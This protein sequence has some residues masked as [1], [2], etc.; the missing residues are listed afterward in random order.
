LSASLGKRVLVPGA[1]SQVGWFLVPRMA[2]AGLKPVPLQRGTR[3]GAGAKFDAAICLA[4]LDTLPPML[5]DLRRCGVRRLIAFSTTGRFYKPDSGDEAERRRVA[6]LVAAENLVVDL[7]KRHE[8]AWT[9]F[10]P[11]LVYGC[12]RDRNVTAIARF[13]RSFGF[14][15]IVDGGHG[16]RQ[17]VHAD[18]LASA[19]VAALDRAVTYCK[20]YTLSGGSVVTYREMVEEVFRQLGRRPR[21]VEVPLPVLRAAIAL[22]HWMPGLRALSPEMASRMRMDLCFDHADAVR[23]FGFRARAFGLDDVAVR[24]A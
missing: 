13:V 15:P 8:I 19:C 22:A 23:D 4:P 18:D 10:R 24:P 17:P 9:L 1:S 6:Q 5:H 3:L 14:F 2:R 12:G 7:C 16:L 11:T 21:V 20:T